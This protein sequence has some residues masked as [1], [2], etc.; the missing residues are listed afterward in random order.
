MTAEEYLRNRIQKKFGVDGIQVFSASGL[1]RWEARLPLLGN[2][3]VS[4]YGSTRIDALESLEEHLGKLEE[5][6]CKTT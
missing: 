5:L 2:R 4:L 3:F 6:K 1:W